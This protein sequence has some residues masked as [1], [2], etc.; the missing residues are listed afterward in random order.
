MAEAGK[1][2]LTVKFWPEYH[3]II[4][5]LVRATPGNIGARLI[6]SYY[7]RAK[8]WA[9]FLE[10]SRRFIVQYVTSNFMNIQ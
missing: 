1:T 3:I 5:L 9:R 4:T 6:S 7:C 8:C 10:R 2:Q